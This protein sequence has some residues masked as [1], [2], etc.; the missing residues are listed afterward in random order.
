M[1]FPARPPATSRAGAFVDAV[2][3]IADDL[4]MF[5][6]AD[7][8]DVISA[9]ALWREM[10]PWDDEHAVKTGVMAAIRRAVSA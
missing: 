3:T 2:S 9:T 4:W 7:A 1:Y 10:N 6:R 5:G 8:R